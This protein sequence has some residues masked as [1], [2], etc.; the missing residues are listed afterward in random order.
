MNFYCIYMV[1]IGYF[2]YSSVQA[3]EMRCIQCTDITLQSR[4]VL[5]E[6]STTVSLTSCDSSTKGCADFKGTVAFGTSQ[7]TDRATVRFRYCAL[8]SR[9]SCY[10]VSNINDLTNEPSG[11]QQAFTKRLQALKSKGILLGQPQEVAGQICVQG[12]SALNGNSRL[13]PKVI[14]FTLSFILTWI[15]V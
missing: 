6:C 10:N 5:S 14:F 3:N 7:A 2:K 13:I 8:D 15:I 12:L 1:L 9:S 4:N 11:I